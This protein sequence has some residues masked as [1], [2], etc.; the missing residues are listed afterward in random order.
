M[1]PNK[2]KFGTEGIN[3]IVCPKCGCRLK[4]DCFT[5]KAKKTEDFI[6]ERNR[7]NYNSHKYNE[8]YDS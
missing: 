1:V 5:T 2:R 7:I 3:W 8:F 4:E 6:K